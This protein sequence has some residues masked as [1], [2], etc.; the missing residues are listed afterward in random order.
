MRVE[1]A[2][3][4]TD[5]SA[6]ARALRHALAVAPAVVARVQEIVARVRAEGD[7][8]VAALTRE[9]DTGGRRP[10]AAASSRPRRSPPRSSA[11]T[12]RSW[13]RS[14]WPRRTCATWRRRRRR[15]S[16]RG[17]AAGPAGAVARAARPPRRRLRARRPRALPQH[18]RDGRRDGPRRRRRADRGVLPAGTEGRS[19]TPSSPR[20]RCAAWPR[21]TPWAARRRSPRWPTGPRRCRRSTSIVGPGNVYV[22]EAKRQVA[23]LVGIDGF[24]GPSELV[25]ILDGAEGAGDGRA[26]PARPGRARPDSPVVALSPAPAALDAVSAALAAAPARRR[27]A[28]PRL[29]DAPDLDA[30]L[31]FAEAFAPEHLQLVGAGPRRWRRASAA[32]D[33]CSSAPSAAPPSATTSP[34]PTT[35]CRPAARRA[36]PLRSRRSTS[37]AACRRCGSRRAPGWTLAR[38]GAA[39]APRRGVRAPR[40]VDGGAHGGQSGDM[41]RTAEIARQTKETDVRLTL[42]LDGTA[43]ASARTGRRLPRPHARPARPPRPPGPRRR[44]HG[45]PA[46]RARHHTVEDTGICLGQALDAALGDRSGIARYGQATVPMDEALATCAIDISGRPYCA[47]R[48]RPAARRHR[49]ASTT[50]WP[51]SSSAPWRRTPELTLH[52][53]VE[54]GTQ[55]APHDRGGLQGLRARAAGGRRA[56]SDAR[57]ACRAPRER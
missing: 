13:P 48:R 39:I 22:Q 38:A 43:P 18:G 4:D 50:S 53:R 8:A 31:A 28:P 1:R 34:A 15:R 2:A 23:R 32:R 51:R 10:R 36:S 17:A 12:R 54:A 57:P 45:R 5:P 24:A 37:G 14:S 26:G 6:A 3:L 56:R 35:C 40:G 9:L 16:R 21:S 25:V 20:A 44:G 49:A 11:P 41:T 42:A 46:R 52:V 19:T 7:E 55:R 29:L 47:L 30:A 27:A 33:A